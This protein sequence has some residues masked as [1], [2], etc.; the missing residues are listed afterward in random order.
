MLS[1][2]RVLMAGGDD[3]NLAALQ[4][5]LEA[6]GHA[7]LHSRS[8]EYVA[9]RLGAGEADVVVVSPDLIASLDRLTE[10]QCDRTPATV[11][12]LAHAPSGSQAR[13]A[14]RAGAA[15]VVDPA[16]GEH[17]LLVAVERAAREG[18]LKRELAMLRA[19]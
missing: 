8:V 5:V 6:A 14:L 16:G 19:R 7:V 1:I 3:P 18:Q 10:A 9:R 4:R 17:V 12:A 2:A 15:E 11:V 13:A